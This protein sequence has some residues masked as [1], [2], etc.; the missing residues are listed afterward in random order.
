MNTEDVKFIKDILTNNEDQ[1]IDRFEEIM[2]EALKKNDLATC[3]TLMGI[4]M[5]RENCQELDF[6]LIKTI[7][8]FGK[9]VYLSTLSHTL[10]EAQIP[11]EPVRVM[12]SRV[13]NSP[14]YAQELVN[15]LKTIMSNNIYR[16]KESLSAWPERDA[17]T[18]RK[19]R[20]M[21]T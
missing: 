5:R 2:Q 11:G 3:S 20:G 9:H 21:L 4:L 17:A 14:E 18:G 1:D 19:L 15:Y 13:L 16:L 7:E 6:L 10:S 12:V 8:A